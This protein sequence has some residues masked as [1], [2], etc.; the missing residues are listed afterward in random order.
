[1]LYRNAVKAIVITLVLVTTAMCAALFVA[2]I[3][4]LADHFTI[5][6]FLGLVGALGGFGWL[7]GVLVRML[8]NWLRIHE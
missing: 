4:T 1:M 8:R 5:D 3:L 7:V 2:A 6:R